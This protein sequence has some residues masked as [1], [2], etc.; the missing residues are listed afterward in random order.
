[1][2][3]AACQDL[4]LPNLE[5]ESHECLCFWLCFWTTS[6]RT[7]IL[8]AFS[9][10]HQSVEQAAKKTMETVRLHRLGG[11]LDHAG[12]GRGGSLACRGGPSTSLQ[13][14]TWS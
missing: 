14:P 10:V 1:M 9:V 6:D 4:Q 2:P 13:R 7:G 11:M 3:V 8:K 12:W 5:G